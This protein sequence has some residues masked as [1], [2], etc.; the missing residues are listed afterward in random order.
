MEGKLLRFVNFILDTVIYLAVIISFFMIMR[1]WVPQENV[2]W[3]SVLSYFLY[4]FIFEFFF[5]QSPAKIIT[6]CKVRLMD[7]HD[8]Y[9]GFRIAART[10]M[11]F[12]PLDL[13]SY[14]FMY[15]G[16]HDR[17]SGTTVVKYK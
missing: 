15:R 14:L 16:F 10:F 6:K 17:I 7:G 12:I 13:L 5:G 2:K 9:H 4:Y 8:G 1:N 11:R 3:I